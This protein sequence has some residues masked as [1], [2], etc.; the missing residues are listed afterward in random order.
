MLMITLPTAKQQGLAW[1]WKKN[2]NQLDGWI[3]SIPI[4]AMFVFF[5]ELLFLIPAYLF[6]FGCFGAW[7]KHHFKGSNGDLLGTAIEGGELWG[8]LI[9]WIYF[10][11]VMG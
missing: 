4:L 3:A 2:I 11:F 9:T 7:V 1:E 8:L 5:H 10:S 6:F